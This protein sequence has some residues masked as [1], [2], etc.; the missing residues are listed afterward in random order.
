[1]QLYQGIDIVEMGKF[2]AVFAEK[3]DLAAEI[4][5][6]REREY[7]YSW[8]D[9]WIHLAG[10]FACK[11]AGIK[12]LEIGLCGLGMTHI[13]QEIEVF[14]SASG[15]P[16]LSLSGWVAKISTRRG[17]TQSTVSISHSGNY[18]VATVILVAS[19]K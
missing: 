16:R 6:E 7:C 12:A 4:F 15:K 8:R 19:L 2:R 14:S 13:F 9:P 5:T 11:E 18:C 17:V 3:P 1:M 10:R